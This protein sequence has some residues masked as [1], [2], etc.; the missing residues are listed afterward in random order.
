[1]EYRGFR[2]EISRALGRDQWVWTVYIPEP[3]SGKEESLAIA[4]TPCFVLNGLST[5]YPDP[6]VHQRAA[7][8][9]R[10]MSSRRRI[11]SAGSAIAGNVRVTRGIRPD[12]LGR[13]VGMCAPA[14]LQDHLPSSFARAADATMG[15]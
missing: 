15:S 8:G 10:K 7:S 3:K 9:G 12:R 6:L 2:Y 11:H 13:A 4:P 1:M 5:F 14:D